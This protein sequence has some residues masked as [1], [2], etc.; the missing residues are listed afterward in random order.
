MKIGSHVSNNGGLMLE[1]A[2]LETIK[3]GAN[4]MMVYMGA[5][6]NTF[7]KS[8]SEMHIE[9]MQR[10]LRQNNIN[11]E[12]VIVHAPYIVNLA[13]VDD[14]K[15][16]YAVSF[17]TNEVKLVAK[18]GAIYM[19][20]HPGAHVGMGYE[21]GLERIAEGIRIILRNTSFTNV[22]ILLETMAGK[23][24]ECGIN[25]EQIKRIIDLVKSD[26]IGV[27]LDTCHIHDAGYD[28]INHYE[29]VINE[30]DRVIGLNYLKAIHLND[31]KNVCSSHKDRHENIGFGEIG[32]DTLMKFVNDERFIDIPK[33]LETPYV[34][35]P[36]NSKLGY[37]PYLEE[38][39][40]IKEGKFNP[41]LKELIINENQVQ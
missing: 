35:D 17:L 18:T 25:F 31:S 21:Y 37:E 27:C 22:V 19:V 15:F 36:A 16:N 14:D 6:Q 2:A 7:R 20:L 12:D 23:G 4:A 13:Q 3:N 34:S 9:E 30:F 39:K 10:L 26:R 40:M 24:T 5:P 33:L 28:I 32:F 8:S 41:N 1:G 38:I 11:L 29:D